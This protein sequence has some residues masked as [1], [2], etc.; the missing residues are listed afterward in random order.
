MKKTGVLISTLS[1][2]WLL[3]G[4]YL[5]EPK[6]ING[7]D[8]TDPPSYI[9]FMEIDFSGTFTFKCGANYIGNGW[10]LTAAHCVFD[11]HSQTKARRVRFTFNSPGGD[12]TQVPV[13]QR[14]VS[15]QIEIFPGYE[16]LYKDAALVFVGDN[17]PAGVEPVRLATKRQSDQW[18]NSREKVIAYGW[19][20]TE[21]GVQS[22]T[23]DILQGVTLTLESEA[24]FLTT[25]ISDAQRVW[26]SWSDY[27]VFA[28]A[29]DDGDACQGDSGGPLVYEGGATPVLVGLTSFG[30]SG[31][32]N[33]TEIPAGYTRVAAIRDW[34][35]SGPALYSVQ[36]HVV[37]RRVNETTGAFSPLFLLMLVLFLL[38]AGRR[39]FARP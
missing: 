22:S 29:F 7:E 3:T 24:S 34:A 31:D 9:V 30:F 33:E 37:S 19:G 1:L 17:V 8:V 36:E 28:G 16:S 32:C 26:N 5:V 20:Q 11:D 12:H 38:V 25:D 35:L 6:I 14:V 10:V 39:R 13:S 18:V 15:S 23:S 4:F 2:W 21:S 27:V